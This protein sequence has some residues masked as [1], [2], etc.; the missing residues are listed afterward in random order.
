MSFA[1]EARVFVTGGDGGN[2][3]RSFRHEKY[4]PLGGPDGGDGGRGGDVILRGKRDV[5]ELS[6]LIRQRR[7]AAERGGD[8]RG[9][10]QHGKRG[11]DLIVHIPLGTLI[12]EGDLLIGDITREGQELVVARGG[13]GGLGNVHFATANR[14]APRLAQRGE[15]GEG[16]WVDLDLKTVGHV[17]FI[18]LP[19]AGKSSLLAASTAAHPEI[20]P[21]P[22]TTLTPN[23]GVATV[24]EVAFVL[25]DVP[26]LIEGAHTGAGLGHRFLRH[27]QRAGV[28][29]YVVDVSLESAWGDYHA[30]REELRLFDETLVAR[31][32][33]VALNKID[34]E[35]ARR[36]GLA[37]QSRLRSEG[38]ESHTVSALTGE[39]M[40]ALLTAIEGAVQR[41]GVLREP[42][43]ALRTY[44]LQPEEASLAV[45]RE[46]G[47][48][49][50][51]GRQAERTVAMADM[52]TDEGL[53]ELQRRLERLGVFRA[54]EGAGVQMGD[55]VRVGDF[56][57]EWT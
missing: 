3:A 15:P 46:G 12:R 41:S 31:I 36:R 8:G 54:L 23:L 18:G 40:E 22:F 53:A 7:F 10:K 51:R 38:F 45:V 56:E 11:V 43:P 33:L 20:A 42:A 49:R 17:G 37:L 52:E 44:R 27:I 5:W 28:L 21:Y 30:V 19:N 4:V 24:A 25:V 35:G 50:V 6:P 48:F 39:G 57:L 13:K 2:G 26:G 9:A 47:S 32:Q 1:D 16:R 14:R 29:V 55:T 34:V